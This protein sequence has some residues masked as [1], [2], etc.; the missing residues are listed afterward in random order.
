MKV[1]HICINDFQGAGLCC[2]RISKAL[3]KKGIDSCVLVVNKHSRDSNVYQTGCFISFFLR[4]LRKVFSFLPFSVND[5]VKL[6]K[7]GKAKKTIY[8]SPISCIDVAN[9]PLLKSAD[10]VHLHWVD[11]FIDYPSFFKKIKKPIVWTLHDE[12]LFYGIAHYEKDYIDTELEH[13]YFRIKKQ[14]LNNVDRLGVVF[15]SNFFYEKFHQHEMIESAK[16]CIIHNSVDTTQFVPIE[17]KFARRKLALEE[18]S[19]Y[20][21]FIAYDITE[22][23]KG[24]NVLIDAL[25]ILGNPSYK[26][27]AIGKHDSFKEDEKV[28]CLGSI[29]DS[30]MMSLIISASD[31]FVMPSNQEAF[32]QTPLETLACGIPVVVFPVSG[33][34]ELVNKENG[35]ICDDFSAES[36]AKGI[37]NVCLEKYNPKQIR[38]DII[39]RFSP[40]KIATDYISFYNLMLKND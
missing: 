21:L 26:I 17:K 28:V 36:L 38:A 4:V 13:K 5:A 25:N 10:I 31:Y 29:N 12:G 7:L 30:K 11:G 14:A 8:S 3:Q 19:V 1:V 39:N 6:Y 35:I 37:Q 16:Q 9:H 18:T 15:L 32:A 22:K 2:Y 33:T 27:L 23:R 20:F 34:K 40:E 24:L